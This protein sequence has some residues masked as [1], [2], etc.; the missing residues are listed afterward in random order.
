MRV[1]NSPQ[2]DMIE[3]N[4]KKVVQRDTVTQHILLERLQQN[5]FPGDIEAVPRRQH[6]IQAAENARSDCEIFLGGLHLVLFSSK[7]LPDPRQS[8]H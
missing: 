7:G 2:P 5:T 4:Q 6:H 8:D 1:C 3:G